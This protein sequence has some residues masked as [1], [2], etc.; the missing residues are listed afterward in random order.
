MGVSGFRH[1]APFV[2][3]FPD[4]L[5][6]C[7]SG[8][9]RYGGYQQVYQQQYAPGQVCQPNRYDY[10]PGQPAYQDRC[11]CNLP[12]TQVLNRTCPETPNGSN[13]FYTL[14]PWPEG[15]AMPEPYSADYYRPPAQMPVQGQPFMGY[16]EPGGLAASWELFGFGG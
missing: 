2:D 1:K 12:E 15:S 13:V 10:A 5:D 9:C 11:L 4:L 3:A 14:N 8:V 16:A 6:S 7:G